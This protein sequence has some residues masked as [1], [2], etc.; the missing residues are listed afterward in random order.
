MLNLYK[1]RRQAI[2]KA[3]TALETYGVSPL[4]LDKFA[5]ILDEQDDRELFHANPRMLATHLQISE[6]EML[7]ILVMGVKEGIVTLNWEVQ[8]PACK[9]IDLSPTHFCELRTLHTCPACHHIHNTSADEEVR[10]SFSIDE[11]LR[12]LGATANDPDFRAR[13]DR[14]YGIVSGHRMLTLQTFRELF[15]RETLPPSESLLVRRVAI[16]FTDLAGSTALYSRRGDTRA[17]DLVRKHFALL[18]RLVDEHNGVVVKTIGDAV[19][20]AFTLPGDAINAAIAM[21]QQLHALNQQLALVPEDYLVLKVGIALGPCV[22]V[23]L[24][25]RP[26]YF[27]TTVNT[28]ARIQAT[29]LGNAIAITEEMLQDE[30]VTQTIGNCHC[31]RRE[32]TLKGFDQPVTVHYITPPAVN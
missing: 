29:S 16:L 30:R 22:S 13:M 4:I 23:T 6:R 11:R 24:N 2:A 19:M 10:I 20:G 15:P 12:K 26:D 25:E 14:R 32:V 7:Q 1:P 3:L 27:G 31:Q 28:A 21:H 5:H 9:G 17:F 8:C 18:F